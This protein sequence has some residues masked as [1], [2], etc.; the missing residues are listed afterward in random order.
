MQMRIQQSAVNDRWSWGFFFSRVLI[1]LL[2]STAA[3]LKV[4]DGTS[5]IHFVL[6]LLEF[7]LS[8]ALLVMGQNALVVLIG[9]MTF[10]GFAAVNLGYLV[11]KV[12]SCGCFGNSI[13]V[14]PIWM[15]LVDLLAAAI[16]FSYCRKLWAV[17]VRRNRPTPLTPGLRHY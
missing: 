3:F 9:G 13:Q 11:S 12:D 5:T 10:S 7:A 15:L 8:Y 14:R 17:R 1:S 4:R 6:P 2:L 16:L